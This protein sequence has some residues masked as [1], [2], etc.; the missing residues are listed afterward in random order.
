MTPDI[1]SAGHKW[2]MLCVAYYKRLLQSKLGV[3]EWLRLLEELNEIPDLH[4]TPEMLAAIVPMSD[5][6]L[7]A[8]HEAMTLDGDERCDVSFRVLTSSRV[9]AIF[10]RLNP[11][12]R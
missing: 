12:L 6:E 9:F 11:S 7:D 2:S 8:V 5:V 10:Q 4:F 3:D 1:V